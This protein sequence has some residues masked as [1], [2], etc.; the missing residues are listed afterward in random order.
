M[1]LRIILMEAD[2][3]GSGEIDFEEFCAFVGK[4]A[5]GADASASASAS[6]AAA[7]K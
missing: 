1:A 7:K 4:E 5:N 6:A 2:L 3:D